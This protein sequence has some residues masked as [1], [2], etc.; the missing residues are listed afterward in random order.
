[1]S[2][3][4]NQGLEVE[5]DRKVF[6]TRWQAIQMFIDNGEEFG[7]LSVMEATFP[8]TFYFTAGKDR[9]VWNPATGQ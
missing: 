5:T 9:I 1:M 2:A 7:F 4:D 3:S 8:G 6:L